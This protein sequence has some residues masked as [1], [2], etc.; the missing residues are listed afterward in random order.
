MGYEPTVA[1]LHCKPE[2][3]ITLHVGSYPIVSLKI[4]TKTFL[5]KRSVFCTRRVPCSFGGYNFLVLYR[6]WLLLLF[7]LLLFF[8]HQKD[9]QTDAKAKALVICVK[10]R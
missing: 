10:N 6:F 1:G 8:F 4:L 5:P 3:A 9:L 7:F 2:L